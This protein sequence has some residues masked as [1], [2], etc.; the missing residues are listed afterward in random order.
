MPE[1]IASLLGSQTRWLRATSKVVLSAGDHRT[2]R[3]AQEAA[4]RD[5]A[6]MT[7]RRRDPG[8]DELIAEITVDC[9]DVDEEL[10]GFEC[11]FDEQAALPC[12]EP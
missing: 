8:L 1:Q 12:P 9:Y 7:P 5:D 2:I 4:E 10:T 6:V 3:G 11:A